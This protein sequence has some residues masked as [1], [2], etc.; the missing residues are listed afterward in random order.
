MPDHL[1]LIVL[2]KSYAQAVPAAELTLLGERFVV[3]VPNAFYWEVFRIEP[4]KRSHALKGFP[5]FRRIHLPE[6]LRKETRSGMPVVEA[7]QPRLEFASMVLEP[8]WT[9]TPEQLQV[10]ED[11]RQAFIDPSVAF[12]MKT[13]AG[14]V[15]GFTEPE[16]DSVLNSDQAFL[17][18][19][20]ELRNPARVRR[21]AK[22]IGYK[23]ADRLD[24]SWFHY[25]LYQTMAFQGIVLR[26]RL[27]GSTEKA[28]PVRLKERLEHDALDLEY[29]LLGLLVGRLAT[30][31][32]S[33][34]L[35]KASMGW[36]FKLLEPQADLL[37]PNR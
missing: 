9:M 22:A 11:Y 14:H 2:D 30:A 21:V 7:N 20:H 1:P 4:E 28:N 35:A 17:D 33:D 19:C 29:L 25:R 27:K 3:L 31:E 8:G 16:N 37:S 6:L 26:W 13:I 34:K 23:H 36:R 12:W 32:T 18:L 15:P 5:E 10:M 24:P